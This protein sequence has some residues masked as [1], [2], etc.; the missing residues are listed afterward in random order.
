MSFNLTKWAIRS[1]PDI[2]GS[3]HHVLITICSFCNSDNGSWPSNSTLSEATGLSRRTIIRAVNELV[4][5]GVLVRINR[6]TKKSQTSNFYSI[7]VFYRQRKAGDLPEFTGP[8]MSHFNYEDYEN[9]AAQMDRERQQKTPAEDGQIDTQ[10]VP[11]CHG[12]GVKLAHNKTSE[13]TT[14][15]NSVGVLDLS[16]ALQKKPDATNAIINGY[17]PPGGLTN[18]GKFPMTLTWRPSQDFLGIARLQGINLESE[19]TQEELM[20]FCVYWIDE[21]KSFGQMQ[22]E[23]KLARRLQMNRQRALPAKGPTDADWNSTDWMD[24]VMEKFKP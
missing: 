7:D 6:F 22:W 14:D 10:D 20:E 12:G 18:F 5:I 13:Q 8:E 2:A 1:T 21:Q 4:E 3:A 19:P 15:Q 24:V 11:N 16:S 23:Q 9:F 17:V